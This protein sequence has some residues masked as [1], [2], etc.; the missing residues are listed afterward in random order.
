M[1][2]RLKGGHFLSLRVAS[3]GCRTVKSKGR[4]R[5]QSHGPGWGWWMAGKRSKAGKGKNKI[6][7]FGGLQAP[8]LLQAG[9]VDACVVCR[10]P[11]PAL[12]GH[13]APPLRPGLTCAPPPR[14][15]DPSRPALPSS[16]PLKTRGWLRLPSSGSQGDT[17]VCP[18]SPRLTQPFQLP[19]DAPKPSRANSPPPRARSRQARPPGHVTGRT[20]I[21]TF[22]IQHLGDVEVFLGHFKGIIQVGDRVVLVQRRWETEEGVCQGQ[23]T[24]AERP[25]GTWEAFSAHAQPTLSGKTV[26]TLDELNSYPKEHLLKPVWANTG[27]SWRRYPGALVSDSQPPTDLRPG[28]ALKPGRYG[29]DGPLQCPLLAVPVPSG[30][31]RCSRTEG[32]AP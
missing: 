5:G 29:P 32:P 26:R 19:E 30:T 27:C 28:P 15:D 17:T 1:G 7:P 16:P 14:R 23:V 4:Q 3:R 9:R 22:R 31:P 24:G 20:A 6:F 21:L 2:T 12:C 25:G 11:E 8:R 18:G 13:L 10:K